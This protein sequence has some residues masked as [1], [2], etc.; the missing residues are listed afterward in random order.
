MGID[1]GPEPRHTPGHGRMT[2]GCAGSSPVRL[3]RGHTA[4]AAG[5]ILIAVV[6]AACGAT[7]P[8]SDDRPT[9]GPVSS[10]AATVGA[11]ASTGDGAVGGSDG[12]P[13][14]LVTP[15]QIANALG[16]PATTIGPGDDSL[17]SQDCT[18][19][20]TD[21]ADQFGGYT[22]SIST[23][24]DLTGLTPGTVLDVTTT[25]VSGV[26]DEAYFV[27]DTG[28]GLPGSFLIFRIGQEAFTVGLSTGNVTI[29]TATQQAIDT[30]LAQDIL[31]GR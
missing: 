13:C 2:A 9:V 1:S 4:W 24:G 8:G 19:A 17:D 7:T 26:G 15:P 30:T 21:P 12:S 29:P 10:S 18:W 16:V 5:L 27:T 25:A 28:T 6:V 22:V 20:Y 31:A 3:V 11:V 23:G 14:E